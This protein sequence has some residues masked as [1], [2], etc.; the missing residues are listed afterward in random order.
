MNKKFSTL[1]CAGLLVSAFTLNAQTPAQAQHIDAL[2]SI[3]GVGAAAVPYFE[4]A[5]PKGMFQLKANDK[6]LIVENDKY[7]LVAPSD[8]TDV[9]SSLWCISIT[10][11]ESQGKN[12]I[13]DFITIFFFRLASAL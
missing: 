3:S 12:P 9:E 5:T 13:F 7:K 4:S 11:T 6:V 8:L 1:L 10:E 2:T